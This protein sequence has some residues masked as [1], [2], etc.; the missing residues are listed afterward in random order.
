MTR[1]GLPVFQGKV[2]FRYHNRDERVDIQSI[3]QHMRYS[4]PDTTSVTIFESPS[5]GVAQIEVHELLPGRE[6]GL[7]P[8]NDTPKIRAAISW[9]EQS[10]KRYGIHKE[11]EKKP[12]SSSKQHPK[13]ISEE[14][15][16]TRRS[17]KNG[18][19]KMQPAHDEQK[20]LRETE[21]RPPGSIH[22]TRVSSLQ[23]NEKPSCQ[24]S[25]Q[26]SKRQS[27]PEMDVMA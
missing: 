11:P 13:S 3:M 10:L 19:A 2:G 8:D 18:P 20:N 15:S 27:T 1:L 25:L 24:A 16:P 17:V 14:T 22:S 6:I 5:E 7:V 26:D 9:L 23:R 4:H 21:Q 12:A